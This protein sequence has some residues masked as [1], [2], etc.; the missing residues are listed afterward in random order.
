MIGP[1]HNQS[2]RLCTGAFRSSPVISLYA[3]TGESGLA[4]RRDKLS[5]QLYARLLGMPHTP[6]YTVIT[7]NQYDHYFEN[8]PR[9]HTTFGYRIRNLVSSLDDPHVNV[10]KSLTY[11]VAPYIMSL[12]PICDGIVTI[13]KSTLPDVIMRNM[14]NNH[15]MME[16]REEVHIYTD[17][18]KGEAGVGFGAVLP[19]RVVSRKLPEAASIFTAEL[20]A[21]L[22]VLSY[23]I[24]NNNSQFVIFSD[25]RSA[26]T[27]ITDAFSKHPIVVE[28]HRWIYLLK[29]QNKIINF[30]WVPAHI[31][32]TGNE[33]ADKAAVEAAENDLPIPD[34]PLPY[35]DYYALF[36]KLL[37]ER[38][39]G[40]WRAVQGNKLRRIKGDIEVWNTSCRKIRQ[41]E[42][43]LCRLRIGH[44][45]YTHGHLMCGDLPPYCDNCIVPLTVEHVLVEC[46]DHNEARD[47]HFPRGRPW[48]SL[49]NI[50]GD[51]EDNTIKL[52]SFLRDIDILNEI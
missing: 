45:R 33:V 32:V 14:F 41:E 49:K 16:H 42:R 5:L 12:Q 2:L 9:I 13:V 1:I 11:D 31:G 28:I 8:N 7:N 40:E 15:K 29:N 21:I 48:L 30:C 4:D 51:E 20:Q 17:G 19:D 52:L 22:Y 6:T 36:R 46:P 26:L 10:M 37:K 39:A 35:K 23:L 38:W 27:S 25:S 3:E 24:R 34:R 43:I 47:L 18:S 44:T 50:L